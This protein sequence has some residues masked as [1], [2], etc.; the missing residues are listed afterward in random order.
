MSKV[1]QSCIENAQLQSFF[2]NYNVMLSFMKFLQQD[3]VKKI[4][5]HKNENSSPHCTR[6]KSFVRKSSV[7][8]FAE[9]IKM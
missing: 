6:E 8:I 9:K 3:V 2:N 7:R 1:S 5:R 4:S